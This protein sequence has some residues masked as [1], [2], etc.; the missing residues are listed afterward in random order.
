MPRPPRRVLIFGR[1]LLRRLAVCCYGAVTCLEVLL[2]K[3]WVYWR[4]LHLFLFLHLLLSQ[5]V[6]S[7]LSIFLTVDTDDLRTTA[8]LDPVGSF[9]L[10]VARADPASCHH[11]LV[12]FGESR[13]LGGARGNKVVVGS[14]MRERW[15]LLLVRGESLLDRLDICAEVGVRVAAAQIGRVQGS[16]LL[17]G[18][19]D[20]A[21]EA[22]PA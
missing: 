20:L 17:I 13:R 5:I 22:E 9:T 11:L 15:G 16:L 4:V 21:A 12:I 3:L 19:V 2:E 14:Q 1:L 6:D 18:S 7:L 8:V 10:A